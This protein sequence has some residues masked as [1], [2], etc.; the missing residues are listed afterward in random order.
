MQYKISPIVLMRARMLGEQEKMRKMIGG[1]GM[2]NSNSTVTQ[3]SSPPQGGTDLF[4][5]QFGSR[6]VEE[7]IYREG[8]KKIWRR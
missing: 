6:W 5:K 4:D 8:Y 3:T 2:P 1:S 7:P